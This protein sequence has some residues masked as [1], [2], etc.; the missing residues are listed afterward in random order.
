MIANGRKIIFVLLFILICAPA[1]SAVKVQKLPLVS[2]V[3]IGL[4]TGVGTG[5]NI[6]FD[7]G[8]NILRFKIGPEFE[9][10]ITTVDNLSNING[11]RL[12]GYFNIQIFKNVSFNFHLGNIDFSVKDGD[13]A[14]TSNGNSYLLLADTSYKGSYQAFSI[15]FSWGDF[16]LSPKLI[17]NTITGGGKLTEFDLNIGRSF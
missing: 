2:D 11:L 8:I 14:Y 7:A 13:V 17:Y 5:I 3:H 12:G 16:M 1:S 9:Q 4:I 15:D 10:I 6:G